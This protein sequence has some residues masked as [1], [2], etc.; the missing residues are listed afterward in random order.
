MGVELR[1]LIHY[2]VEALRAEFGKTKLAGSALK[3]GAQTQGVFL[4]GA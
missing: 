4:Q 2:T 1:R 3:L